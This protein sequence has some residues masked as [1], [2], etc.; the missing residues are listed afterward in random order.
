MKDARI[1]VLVVAS[2]VVAS[3]AKFNTVDTGPQDGPPPRSGNGT[4]VDPNSGSG[5]GVDANIVPPAVAGSGQS[6]DAQSP[7]SS[8]SS[9]PPADA[10]GGASSNPAGVSD[11]AP[12]P[13]TVDS[14][15]PACQAGSHNCNGACVDNKQVSS[16]GPVACDTCPDIKG[17]TPTCD[18]TVCG[19]MCPAGQKLCMTECIPTAANCVTSCLAGAECTPGQT[20]TMPCGRCGQQKDTCS[21][22]CMWTMGTCSKEGVCTPGESKMSSCGNCGQRMDTCSSS[23]QWTNGTCGNQG[24]HPGD[25]RVTD[26]SCGNKCGK[27]KETCS[28]ACVFVAS[29]CGNE[30]ECTRGETDMKTCPCG[31][32][33]STCSNKCQFVDGACM[34]E[35]VCTPGEH[36]TV[37]CMGNGTQTNTC[38]KSC[39]FD[40][41]SCV[42]PPPMCPTLTCSTS[43]PCH[44]SD[45]HCDTKTGN[46]SCVVSVDDSSNT[47]ACAHGCSGGQCVTIIQPRPPGGGNPRPPG[48]GLPMC[49]ASGAPCGMLGCCAPLTCRPDKTCG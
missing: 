19:G 15:P 27:Q 23:C 11:A 39:H 12:D 18:G 5:S 9:V 38:N 36:Q 40:E 37:P 29:G 4:A 28:P 22:S 46:A 3:C 21:S 16:C 34:N 2:L 8:M 14:G 43:T 44:R 20:R 33:I 31:H 49:P 6:A 48:G 25:S 1:A 45:Y 42:V 10:M 26:S 17:G 41:G 35:G 24:C 7:A 32:L 30:G 47:A 13:S